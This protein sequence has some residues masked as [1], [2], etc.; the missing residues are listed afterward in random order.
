MSDGGAPLGDAAACPSGAGHGSLELAI[1]IPS[2]VAADVRVTGGDGHAVAI[3]ASASDTHMLTPGRYTVSAHRVRQ[4]GDL[5]G[6]AYQG[7]VVEAGEVCVRADATATVHVDYTREPGSTRAWLTQTNGDGAQVMAFDADQLASGGE[8]TPS[9]SLAPGLTNVG[10]LAVDGLGRL[11][12]G[13]NTGKLVAF[14]TARM[15]STSSSAPDVVLEGA[16]LCE[17]T[18][19]CGPRAIAFDKQGALWVATLSRIVKLAPASLDRSGEP[20]ASLTLTSPD[21]QEPRALAFDA[22]G[23]LWVADYHSG[24]IAKFAVAALGSGPHS[25][26]A[27]TVLYAQQTGPVTATLTNPEALVF[28][29]SGNLWVPFSN[30]LVRFSKTELGTSRTAEDPLT[31]AL[32]MFVGEGLLVT[33]LTLDEQG[34]LWLPGPAGSLYQ[35][36]KDEFAH[37][38]PTL[39]SLHSAEMG[40]VERLTFN[41][42]PGA[43]FI[44]P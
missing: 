21:A 34:N 1:D 18:L 26:H 24:A 33:D 23:A 39:K 43:L 9:V 3:T 11:W 16:A 10:P 5:M 22:D 8:Q 7:H 32:H 37:E 17:E 28:D 6:A 40:S 41:T 14:N 2:A 12:V 42:V 30:Y 27:V 15:G 20:A 29:A 38:N 35:I 4:A 36:A 19:P 44:A 13:T 31:P 25:A